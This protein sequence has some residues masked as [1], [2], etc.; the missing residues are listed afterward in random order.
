MNFQRLLLGI[1]G[2]WAD[3]GLRPPAALRHR[4]RRGDD[5]PGHLLPRA[6]PRAVERRLLPAVAAPGRWPLRREPDAGLQALSV[7]GHPRSRRRSTCSGSISTRCARSASIRWS[8][9]SASRRTTGS[10]RRWARRAWA[11][12][13]SWTGWRSRSSPTSSRPADASL[14]PIPVE[15]TYGIERICMF[16]ND[17]KNIFDIPW[18]D[19]G[20]TYG[21][22]RQR[23]EVEHSIYSFREADV[24]AASARSSSSGSARR[25]A[26]VAIPLVVPRARSGAQVLAPVQRARRARGALDDRARGVHPADPAS[27]PAWSRTP[28]SLQRGGGGIPSAHARSADERAAPHRDR[29]RGDPGADDRAP[30]PRPA[31]AGR[32]R[33]RSSRHRARS[34]RRRGAAPAASRCAS[35]R[36]RDAPGEGRAG[37]WGRPRRPRFATTGRRRPQA[38]GS[39]R[40]RG[41]IRRRSQKIET[42][43]GVYAGFRRARG[44]AQRWPR[45]SRR[46]F[47]RRSRR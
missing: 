28:T 9:T 4:G 22:V 43:K 32:R 39:R 16:L 27:W 18:N 11:G 29:L 33:P 30:R 46:R 25:R 40:S 14:A 5:A 34:R 41:S 21:D 6:G 19:A 37:A 7:P 36:R 2:F 45:C 12:R 23:E 26:S 20:I 17:I 13:S 1:Q 3:A 8:T 42:E 35:R 38:M 31:P 10:R 24:A 44:G 47:R 15:L